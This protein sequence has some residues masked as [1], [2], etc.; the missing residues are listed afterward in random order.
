MYLLKIPFQQITDFFESFV[1]HVSLYPAPHPENEYFLWISEALRW[2]ARIQWG[3]GKGL[4]PSTGKQ[5]CLRHSCPTP[6]VERLSEAHLFCLL[7][8]LFIN[9]LLNNHR[10][11]K[12]SQTFQFT[13]IFTSHLCSLFSLKWQNWNNL[14]LAVTSSKSY[15]QLLFLLGSTWV[16]IGDSLKSSRAIV[17]VDFPPSFL[18]TLRQPKCHF[19]SY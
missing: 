4:E 13:L 11:R 17:Q 12:L 7:R 10:D 6:G 14:E 2:M 15:L 5:F 16:F 9:L 3:E 18:W 8:Q 19:D 1:E